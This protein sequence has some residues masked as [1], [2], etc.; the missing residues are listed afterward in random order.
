MRRIYIK[1]IVLL[2][3]VIIVNLNNCYSA[4][5]KTDSALI[6][7]SNS[8][9]DK[10]LEIYLSL[11][12]KDYYSAGLF[13]NIANCYYKLNDL[14]SAILWY[15]RARIL[16]P[17]NEDIKVNLE[18][19]NSQI[20]NKVDA[21]PVVFYMQWYYKMINRFNSDSWAWIGFILFIIFLG[22]I[23]AY[24]FSGFVNIKKI[25]F[26]VAIFSLL[27]FTLSLHFSIQQKNNQLY[28]NYA[29]V[30]DYSLVKSSPNHESS[31]LFQ[32]HEGLKVEVIE[33]L[34]EWSNIR[35]ADGKQG[36]LPSENI[37]RI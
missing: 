25:S 37:E 16:D 1:I 3:T 12:E 34:N 10:A 35:L 17:A 31:N 13:Y 30:F 7:Y 28:N 22:S 33:E 2:F 29:I 15:E 32:I 6:Y 19:A 8:E 23:I 14:P 11:N 18:I 4:T 26:I 21:L 5:E 20:K 27:L 9:Y 36:W 24:L